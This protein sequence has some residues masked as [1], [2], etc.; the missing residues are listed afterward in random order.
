MMFSLDYRLEVA[1]RSDRGASDVKI[2]LQ[3]S[4]ARHGAA[5]APNAGAAQNLQTLER[6]GAQQSRSITGT[7]RLPV[8]ELA[9]LKQGA[10]PLFVPLVHIMIEG[11]NIEA[12]T[13]SY[14]IGTPSTISITRVH[15]LALDTPPGSIAGLRAQI[16]DIPPD[17]RE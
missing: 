2:A 11:E 13:R 7:L 16:I 14:L 3:L 6:I 5:N 12:F 15:P 17:R 1:N 4:C 10:T 8:A 9:I